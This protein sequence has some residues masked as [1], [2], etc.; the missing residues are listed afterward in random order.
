MTWDATSAVT[1]W[2]TGA[3]PN[4]GLYLKRHTEPSAAGGPAPPGMRFTGELSLTPRLVVTVTSGQA[5]VCCPDVFTGVATWMRSTRSFLDR[6]RA[7]LA[8]RTCGMRHGAGIA[9]AR[10]TGGCCFVRHTAWPVSTVWLWWLLSA[11]G[12][13]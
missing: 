1:K 10:L 9:G 6:G 8:T 2:V 12:R 13:Y 5:L 7:C 11:Y 4:F 3:A